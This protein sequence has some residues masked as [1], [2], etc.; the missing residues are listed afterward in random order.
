MKA[1]LSKVV[2]GP[3][4]LV[5]EDVAV[6]TPGKGQV[7]VQ[8]K[9]CGVN[10]PDVLIIQDM[11]QFKPP[12]PFSPGGEVAGIVAAVGEGVAHV[13]PG[14]RVL[15]STGSGGMAEYC[16]AAA[17]GVMPIPEGMPFEEAAAFLMTYG[18]SYYALKDRGDPKPGEKLLV[19]GAAG[20]V[21]IAAVELGKAMGLEVIAAASSQE[22]VD[23]C[24][25]KGADKGLVYARE[26]DRD[27][28]KKFSEDIKA[29]S[30][31]GVDI[32]YDGVG[33]NYAEPAVRAMN[34]EG[35][36]LVIGFPAGI[37]KLPLNLTLLKS[38]DVRGVF[39]GAA[40]ARD[41]KAHQQNVKELFDL[42]KAGKIRPHISGSYPMEQ[43]AD[44]IREL[45]DRKAQGKVVVTM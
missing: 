12:R 32:I 11:Y 44:A 40:V 16:L 42:Y 4:A 22:K 8:V 27:G 24:L 31:G 23:F 17:H 34:W 35:R 19:L 26:L 2:G 20:G 9:A 18:T 14:E 37:P 10:Y 33:G 41:P 1:V 3:E 15:A 43:A 36:F 25:S 13:K 28:Q 38:C 30:G 39:W 5:I 21:G 29:I 7:L 6:P 45:Q